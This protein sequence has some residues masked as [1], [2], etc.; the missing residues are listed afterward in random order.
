MSADQPQTSSATEAGSAIGSDH[1]FRPIPELA[2]TF[3]VWPRGERLAAIRAGAE[4][5]KVRFTEQGRVHSVRSV[6]L[7]T[8]PYVTKYAFHGAARS[9]N[10]YLSMMN[11]MIVIRYEDLAGRDRVLVWEPTE[12]EGSAEAPFYT[13]LLER[14]ER[15]LL[16]KA[17][18]QLTYKQYATPEEALRIAGVR[19]ED[20]DFI[21]FD[22]L[23]V[24][25]PR[26][27]LPHFPNARLI[28]QRK[29][30]ATLESLHPMQ[31][32][33]YVEDGLDGIDQERF[34]PI[35]GD[36][37][38]GVGV[39][40]AWTPG[41]TDGNHSLVINTPDGVWVSSEN[42]VASDNWQPELSKIPGVREYAVRMR[43]EVCPNAN[44][45]E[46]SIDQYDSMVK[47]KTLAD[48]S[49]RDPRWKQVLPSSELVSWRRQWP[50]VP[51]HVHGQLSYG[52]L[53]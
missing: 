17:V 25:D 15:N 20:V 27:I 5:F 41:H 7:A 53:G 12:P 39:A 10:P 52:R 40:I 46:D 29:E 48:P 9:L 31:W 51:T 50:I 8:A 14:T 26:L 49:R 3:D 37:E 21:S 16:F 24:Q 33:W 45:L 6:D 2:G 4:R 11:R 36:V 35:E 23:H 34:L 43:R 13:Q 32:F 18:E 42:G 44:T 22:H 47:E 1:G 19:A 30:L 38:L 28:V